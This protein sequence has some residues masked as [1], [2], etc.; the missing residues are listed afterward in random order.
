MRIKNITKTKILLNLSRKVWLRS[1]A[2]LTINSAQLRRCK[3]YQD[4]GLIKILGAEGAKLIAVDSKAIKEEVVEVPIEAPPVEEAIEI[5]PALEESVS[6]EGN[7][8]GEKSYKELKEIATELGVAG[9]GK[10]G[11]IEAIKNYEE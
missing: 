5:E 2:E 8:L 9:K 4:R 11:L 10:K 7:D 1:G 6:D 3:M